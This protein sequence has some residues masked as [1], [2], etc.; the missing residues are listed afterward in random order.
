MRREN[1]M[2]IRRRTIISLM[3]MVLGFLFICL[4]DAVTAGE[5]YSWV[6]KNGTMIFSEFPPPAE[7]T[8]KKLNLE[9]EGPLKVRIG[10]DKKQVLSLPGWG[11]PQNT[12]T[13]GMSIAKTEV[14]SMWFYGHGRILYF[15]NEILT[16]IEE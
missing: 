3:L 14:Y 8:T 1:F 9:Q 4:V 11:K 16:K 5:I 10:M 12:S 15:T 13:Y 6:D 2:N 7:T